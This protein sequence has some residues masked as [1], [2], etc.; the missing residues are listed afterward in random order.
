MQSSV[1]D[2]QLFN[3]FCCVYGAVAIVSLLSCPET[4]KWC[5]RPRGGFFL[6]RS[7]STVSPSQLPRSLEIFAVRQSSE[8]P[9]HYVIWRRRATEMRNIGE[10]KAKAGEP[11]KQCREGRSNHQPAVLEYGVDTSTLFACKPDRSLRSSCPL[12]NI[13]TSQFSTAASIWGYSQPKAYRQPVPS[14]CTDALILICWVSAGLRFCWY[15]VMMS[16]RYHKYLVK[17]LPPGRPSHTN[18]LVRTCNRQTYT[19]ITK[20]SLLFGATGAGIAT[21]MCIK[22]RNSRQHLGVASQPSLEHRKFLK[23]VGCGRNKNETKTPLVALCEELK[24]SNLP[25]ED[26]EEGPIGAEVGKRKVGFKVNKIYNQGLPFRTFTTCWYGKGR[27]GSV[28]CNFLQNHMLFTKHF[29]C[30]AQFISLIC[31]LFHTCLRHTCV[32]SFTPKYWF[33]C[34]FMVPSIHQYVRHVKAGPNEHCNQCNVW[35]FVPK[36][37][38]RRNMPHLLGLYV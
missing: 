17:L 10:S 28:E 23:L 4:G 15:I 9:S 27:G 13:R 2:W 24:L 35:N 29:M 34:I 26:K 11:M 31:H 20:L 38:Q 16:S 36:I 18:L 32:L 37:P 12:Q 7:I 6:P 21:Y 5:S 3:G 1:T 30:H 22:R 33:S 19:T 14:S 8:I 25:N